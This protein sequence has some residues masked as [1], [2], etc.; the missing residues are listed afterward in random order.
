LPDCENIGLP[1]Q[2]YA[3]SDAPAKIAGMTTQQKTQA[4]G[5][6]GMDFGTT[7][8]GIAVP[9]A[10][11]TLK[12]LPID[13]AASNDKVA[14][15]AIY[16]TN[17]QKIHIGRDAVKAYTAQNTGRSVRMEK[18]WVGEIE[19]R[20]EDMYYVQDVYVFIDVLSPGRL[21]LSIK[22]G[23]RD[24]SFLGTI[25]GQF[26]YPLED[27]ISLYLTVTKTRAEQQLGREIKQVVLGRPVRFAFEP[28][29][30]ALAQTRLLDAAIR[31]GY[32]EVWFQ[33]EPV[34]AAYDYAQTI[35]QAENVLVFDFGGGT[36]DITIM[37]L[38]PGGK[39][40]EILA[41]GG[42]PVA[43]DVFDQKV[44]RAKLP[45]HF[46]EGSYYSTEYKKMPVPGWIFDIFSDWQRLLELQYPENREIL[47][48][49]A[50]TAHRPREIA[51]LQRLVRD[52]F[53]LQM[54]DAVEQA[55]RRLSDD[56]GTLIHFDGPGFNIRQ[57]VTRTEFETIIRQDVQAIDKHL[58]EII[59]QS[60]L[61]LDEIDSVIR[62]G[63]SAEIPVF[64]TMLLSRFGRKKVRAVDTFSSVT[65][66]LGIC[67]QQIAEGTLNLRKWTAEDLKSHSLERETKVS[68]V[69]LA[70]LQKRIAFQEGAVDMKD[71][72]ERVRIIIGSNKLVASQ[73]VDQMTVPAELKIAAWARTLSAGFDD[74]I[75]FLTNLY[76]FVLTTP[77]V[78]AEID[79][80]GIDIATLYHFRP[81]EEVTSGARW[82][83]IA[84]ASHLTF[85]TSR[86]YARSLSMEQILDR[87][88]SPAPYKFDHAPPG[89]PINVFGTELA[90]E[91]VILNDQG[92]ILRYP[93]KEP[94]IRYRGVQVMNWKAGESVAG[95]L[96]VR[97]GGFGEEL[98]VVT[99]TGY[100]KRLNYADIP[101]ADKHNI[102]PPLAIS[103]K[104]VVSIRLQVISERSSLSTSHLSLLTTEGFADGDLGKL[105]EPDG[106]TKSQ[107]LV[108][109]KGEQRVLAV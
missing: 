44:T 79:E 65:A 96:H 1:Y 42:I 62:T 11:G 26:Y 2:H 75:L 87:I 86:G 7:N 50:K 51:A 24:E 27:I 69:N 84:E 12:L 6:I 102:R 89:V 78:L 88:E 98:V 103:R 82:A 52:N 64:K 70:L 97:P 3:L 55:K 108:K 60:G 95:S 66:G 17:D 59:E 28:E 74:Q 8:S 76:R 81:M 67:A 90:D 5:I 39:G 25:V 106:T 20:A 93:C 77:R 33:Y 49:I 45:K 36:L 58:D 35:T 16:I 91:L 99:A 63:G 105:A 30:D 14:R 101:L 85:V 19:V 32:E 40:H 71:T 61:S 18:V 56:M 13:P 94:R 54:F 109:V 80:L 68:P 37:R 4:A 34:A 83:D 10:D 15:T 92:R 43:G 57:M 104:P 9:M 47:D 22:S 53:G 41:T 31:A 46:G 38:E 48:E 72:P 73:P 23:L 21:F 29:K 100:G 107:V